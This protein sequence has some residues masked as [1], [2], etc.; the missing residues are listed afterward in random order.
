MAR[1]VLEVATAARPVV[2]VEWAALV[3]VRP[4]AS[5]VG[6]NPTLHSHLVHPPLA[7]L[8]GLATDRPQSRL[9]LPSFATLAELDFLTQLSAPRGSKTRAAPEGPHRVRQGFLAEL[10][11]PVGRTPRRTARSAARSQ[12]SPEVVAAALAAVSQATDPVVLEPVESAELALVGL[13][14]PVSARATSMAS[15]AAAPPELAL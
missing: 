6:S 1:V 14:A 8:S 12:A 5:T 3:R 15:E 4:P 7:A 11:S 2:P 9:T 13:A 10:A